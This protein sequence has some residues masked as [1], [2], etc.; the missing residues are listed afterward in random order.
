MTF[1]IAAL[2]RDRVA[3]SN[4]DAVVRR[5]SGPEGFIATRMNVPAITIPDRIAESAG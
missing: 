4:S 1:Q 2:A 3:A 5:S